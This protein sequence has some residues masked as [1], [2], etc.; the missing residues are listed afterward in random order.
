MRLL[1]FAMIN[2]GSNHLRNDY[3]KHAQK[4]PDRTACLTGK[5]A[6]P[7][8]TATVRMLCLRNRRKG[9]PFCRL[10]SENGIVTTPL[11]L[12]AVVAQ[13]GASW[14]IYQREK[15]RTNL[16]CGSRSARPASI[17]DGI[18]PAAETGE[19][20]PLFGLQ[21]KGWRHLRPPFHIGRAVPAEISRLAEYT[22]WR[23]N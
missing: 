19:P 3:P 18:P 9:H 5:A 22:N 21:E 11:P 1:F 23:Q 14:G 20:V 16:R 6:L 4:A 8:G 2:H 12:N 17:A 7:S 13:R 15:K 10:Q